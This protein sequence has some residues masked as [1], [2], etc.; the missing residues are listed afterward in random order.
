M[1]YPTETEVDCSPMPT[2]ESPQEY[3]NRIM[4]EAGLVHRAVAERAQALG[5][6][7]SGGYVHNIASG[8]INNPTVKLLQALA[9]GLGRPEDEVFLVFRGKAATEE[10]KDSLFATIWN[11]YKHLPNGDQK[12]LRVVL[13][14]LHREIQRR[15]LKPS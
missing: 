7:L 14:M 11:E 12:E 6:K 5:Y 2:R 9:V 13:N 10:Y 15:L 8:A 1:L 3:V 4:R